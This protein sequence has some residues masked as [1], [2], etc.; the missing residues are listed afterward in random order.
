MMVGMEQRAGD[1]DSRRALSCISF[2]ACVQ[3]QLGQARRKDIV[4]AAICNVAVALFQVR[5]CKLEVVRLEV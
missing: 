1:L 2:H 3:L 5:R 4:E